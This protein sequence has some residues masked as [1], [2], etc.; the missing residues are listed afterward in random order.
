MKSVFAKHGVPTLLVI[1]NGPQYTSRQMQ[2]FAQQYN[3]K[4]VTSSPHHP[5]S[6]G[7]AEHSC[8]SHLSCPHDLLHCLFSSSSLFTCITAS[9]Y[10]EHLHLLILLLVD[11]LSVVCLLQCH[12]SPPHCEVY[13]L[14]CCSFTRPLLVKVK[15]VGIYSD[16]VSTLRKNALSFNRYSP[17]RTT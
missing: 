16:L 8:L 2:L 3:F 12:L 6:N 14:G 9:L 5:Q 11:T 7:L 4:Q 15:T 1:D 17:S 13:A 10:F